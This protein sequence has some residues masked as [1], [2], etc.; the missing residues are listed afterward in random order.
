M[1]LLIVFYV[2][3]LRAI[4]AFSKSEPE[5]RRRIERDLALSPSGIDRKIVGGGRYAF[6]TT[7]S[8][9]TV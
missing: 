4:D 9:L 1:S 3:A 7:N 5:P 8:R 2:A 6:C